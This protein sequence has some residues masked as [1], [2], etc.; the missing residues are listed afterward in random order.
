MPFTPRRPRQNLPL[1]L[2]ALRAEGRANPLAIPSGLPPDI[3][4][5]LA[6]LA[7]LFWKRARLIVQPFL[8][9]NVGEPVQIRPQES[10]TYFFIQN[11]SGATQMVVNFGRPG[12]GLAGVPVDGVI[13]G[14]G[15]GFY[16]P[17]AVPQDAIYVG[18][19]AAGTPGVIVYALAGG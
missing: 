7:P 14:A 10:R 12:S 4:T 6:L 2:M 3:D 1:D 16:E 5:L 17:I 11:Q 15:L 18:A 13:L 8:A 19:A 9:T